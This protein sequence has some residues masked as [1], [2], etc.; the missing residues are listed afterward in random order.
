MRLTLDWDHVFATPMVWYVPCVDGCILIVDGLQTEPT[1][2]LSTTARGWTDNGVEITLLLRC[3]DMKRL[4]QDLL[5]LL[6][7]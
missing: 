6:Q 5:F 4:L 2:L 7:V 1:H 3:E